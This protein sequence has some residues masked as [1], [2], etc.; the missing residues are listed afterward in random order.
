MGDKQPEEIIEEIERLSVSFPKFALVHSDLGVLYYNNGNKEKALNHYQK[1]VQLEPANA[2]FQKNLGDYYLVELDRKEDALQ[3][4][5]GLLSDHPNDL[6]MNLTVAHICVAVQNFSQ[7]KVL[8][9]RVLVIDPENEDAR[10][11]LRLLENIKRDLRTD[12]Q[13]KTE[14]LQKSTPGKNSPAEE[15]INV[16]DAP[17]KDSPQFSIILTTSAPLKQFRRCVESIKKQT[18]ESHE[19]LFVNNGTTKGVLK[20][21]RQCIDENRNY[22][23]VKCGKEANPA[24]CDNT[25]IKAARGEYIVLLSNDV[26]VTDGWLSSMLKCF[27][28]IPDAGM[29]GTMANRARGRQK[30][31]AAVKTS[32]TE[33]NEFAESYRATNRCRRIVCDIPDGFCLLF[34]RDL[35][36]KI[37][38][39]DEQMAALGFE[40]EDYCL[41]AALEGYVNQIAGDVYLHRLESKA[42][43][44]SRKNFNLKWSGADVQSP[45]GK[46]HLALRAVEKANRA[47]EEGKIDPAVELFLQAIGLLPERKESYYKLAELLV[48]TK[49]FKDALDVLNEVAEGDP[50]ARQ[51]ELAACCKEGLELFEEAEGYADQA[52]EI[53]RC[54]PSALNTKGIIAFRRDDKNA[55]ES[56]SPVPWK[57]I[58]A[59]VKPI[60][61]LVPSSGRQG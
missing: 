33:I 47:G 48:N 9:N 38:L 45:T 40:D 59:S 55:A 10:N 1:A 42:P 32:F 11:N 21:I 61:I 43:A 26:V 41:R 18:S 31:A 4:Y 5:L 35:T 57:R 56:Y 29:V 39:F 46:R 60:P 58:P 17:E 50:D 53:S 34:R 7:A 52:I 36:E 23:L 14:S 16:K 25:G 15:T 22:R 12:Q 8:Y 6:E 24:V 44:R 13:P 54:A 37:G 2:T 30:V 3:I 19:I 20:W 28:S 51:L 27:S 49:R